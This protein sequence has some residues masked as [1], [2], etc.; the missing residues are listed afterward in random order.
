MD[1]QEA[2]NNCGLLHSCGKMSTTE[3]Q[4]YRFSAYGPFEVFLYG[5]FALAS[6]NC[7][8]LVATM[9]L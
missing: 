9:C 6:G 8:I 2:G 4:I 7:N 5:G 1:F 3:P